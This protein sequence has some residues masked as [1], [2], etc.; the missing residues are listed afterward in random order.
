MTFLYV[1]RYVLPP[2]PGLPSAATPVGLGPQDHRYGPIDS[3]A[4]SLLPQTTEA[5]SSQITC[6]NSYLAE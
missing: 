4:C 1:I 2:W 5:T 6:L 3:L